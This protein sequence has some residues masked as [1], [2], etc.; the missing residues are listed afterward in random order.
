ME[1]SLRQGSSGAVPKE[2][3]RDWSIGHDPKGVMTDIPDGTCPATLQE[4]RM[5]ADKLTCGY[6]YQRSAC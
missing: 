3:N 4:A 6:R 5:E 2:A 1:T